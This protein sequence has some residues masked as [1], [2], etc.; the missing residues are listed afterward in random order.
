MRLSLSGEGLDQLGRCLQGRGFGLGL[1][2]VWMV[3]ARG[4]DLTCLEGRD[5]GYGGSVAEHQ[6]GYPLAQVLF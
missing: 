2:R 5:D 4:F 1:W 3:G 6:A